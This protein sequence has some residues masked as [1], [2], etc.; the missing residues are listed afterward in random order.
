MNLMTVKPNGLDQVIIQSMF[1]P[2]ERK[3]H[4]FVYIVNKCFPN[5]CVPD[6]VLGVPW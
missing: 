2:E 6:I 5:H 1:M 4:T 3:E